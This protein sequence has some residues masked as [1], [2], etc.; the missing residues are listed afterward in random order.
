MTI[1]GA[2]SVPSFGCYFEILLQL[3]TVALPSHSAHAVFEVLMK[4]AEDLSSGLTKPEDISFMKESLLKQECTILPT[5]QDIWVSLHPS[6][7]VIC[8]PDDEELKKQFKYF[9]G[10]NFVQFGELSNKER[11]VLYGNVA[12]LLQELGIPRLSEVVFRE[13]IFYGTADSKEKVAL[14]N[15][16]LPYAQCYLYKLHPDRYLELKQLGF[17][18]LS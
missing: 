18:K 8:W 14:I 4:I 1:C 13:A 15:W 7:G 10:V 12:I 2:P 11:D 5:S 9:E 6:F 17:V 16:V 3:S